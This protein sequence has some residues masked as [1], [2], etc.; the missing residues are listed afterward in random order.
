MKKK[1][2]WRLILICVTVIL[3]IIFFL[4]NTPAFQHMP[5][6][7]KNNMPNKGIVLRLDLGGLHLVFEVEGDKVLK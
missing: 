4:P 2:L 7:W 1:I 6:W 5:D 3:A